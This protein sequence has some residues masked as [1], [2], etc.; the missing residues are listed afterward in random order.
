MIRNI[1]TFVSG[2]GRVAGVAIDLTIGAAKLLDTIDSYVI[3][4]GVGI[5][6]SRA[7]IGYLGETFTIVGQTAKDVI[8]GIIFDFGEIGPAA[9]R[10]YAEMAAASNRWSHN[11]IQDAN[12]VRFA[13]MN[14][15]MTGTRPGGFAF[16]GGEKEASGPVQP[17]PAGPPPVPNVRPPAA[18]TGGGGGMEGAANHMLTLMDNLKKEISNLSEGSIAA[19][20]AWY[21]KTVNDINKLVAKGVEGEEALALAAQA[22]GLK[23]EKV[24]ADFNRLVAKEGGNAFAELDA[25]YLEDLRKY[26]GIAGAKEALDD[27]WYKRRADLVDKF[28]KEAADLEKSSLDKMAAALPLLSQQLP[29]KERILA[30]ELESNRAADEK[31]LRELEIN[32]II[33]AS[34]ANELRGLR[35]LSD[36][37]RRYALEREKWATQGVSGGVKLFAFDLQKETETAIAFGVRDGLKGAKSYVDQAI[38]DL[39]MSPFTKKKMDFKKIG[40]DIAT[41]IASGLVKTGTNK[42][43]SSLME[44]TLNMASTWQTAQQTMTAAS[45][46]GEAARL[47]AASGGAGQTMGILATLGKGS[48]LMDAGRSGAAAFTSVMEALPFP[49]NAVLAPVAAAAAFAATLAFG[50]GFGSGGGGG[51]GGG[52][53]EYSPGAYHGGGVVAHTGWLVAHAGL[54]LAA[55]ERHIIA[56]VGEGILQNS[57]MD[58]WA[59]AG[60]GF[61][62]LNDPTRLPVM[63]APLPLPVPVTTNTGS[64]GPQKLVIPLTINQVDARGQVT[65]AQQYQLTVDL[66]N[67]AIKHHEIL[68]PKR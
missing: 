48:I 39:I 18:D 21:L 1:E 15:M 56:R 5:A 41:S 30:I 44:N 13:V 19:I 7:S 57:A 25:R 17:K 63:A 60:V 53:G 31:K 11:A 55:D 49:I 28:T 59:R 51:T 27:I 4:L 47:A 58:K 37:A 24:A 14:S 50:S 3:K 9:S 68:I 23:K 64:G 22:A 32:G 36:Q 54:D 65:Q 38:T 40:L 6:I 42:F 35:A 20:D 16:M 61:D 66:V 26:Q 8:H 62:L 45:T 46:A 2:I 29:L 34:Q 12:N 33:S 43:F 52:P 67:K 10:S